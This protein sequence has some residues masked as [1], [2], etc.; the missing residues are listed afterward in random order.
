MGEKL[1][2]YVV[3][4]TRATRD[5]SEFAL[6]IGPMISYRASPRASIFWLGIA[7]PGCA[8]L[9]GRAYVRP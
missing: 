8:F 4:F 9:N 2:D 6:D 3:R 5:P 7:S 1:V